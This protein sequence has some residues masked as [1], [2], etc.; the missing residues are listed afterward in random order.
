MAGGLP[1]SESLLRLA[2]FVTALLALGLAETL[3]PRRDADTRRSRW[4]G[5]LGLG[6]LNALLLRAVV[7]GSLVG[8]AVWVE[9]NQLGLLPWPDTSPSAASTLYKAAV[10]VL[11]GAPAAAVLIFEVLLS[12]TALFSHANLRLPHWF[13]KALRLLIVTPDMHRIHHSI[14]PA[15][16]DR[17]FG[18]CLASWDRLFATY[19]ERPTAGQRAMTVGVKELEHERQS[20][21]A[22]LA[23]P[24]RIP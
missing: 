11:L 16:T 9:A 24:V 6:L 10:I 15:E 8:V 14:D 23:Q 4:P 19:R 3:W 18:F 2:V 21:G 12:T 17:N 20:L 1:E 22:M 13:D 7:P 5:N